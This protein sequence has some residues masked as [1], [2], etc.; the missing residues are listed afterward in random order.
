MRRNWI[1][2]YVD[3]CLR[4]T[5][6][7]ELSNEERWSWIGFLLLAGDSPFEGK[8]SLTE[9]M[10]YTDQQ[11]ASLIK[12]PISTLKKAKEKMIKFEKIKVF[13]NNIIQIVNWKRYQSDYKR[14]K[15]HRNP[16]FLEL[17][18]SIKERDGYICQKCHK[19]ESKLEVPLCIH[20]IDNDPSNNHEDNLITLCMTCHSQLYKKAVHPTRK[21][22]RKTQEDKFKEIVQGKSSNNKFN[23]EREREREGEREKKRRKKENINKYGQ[24]ELDKF[25]EEFWKGYP[26][27]IAKEY[28]KEKFMILARKGLIKDLIQATNGYMD[29]LKHR[30]INDNFEQEPMNPATFL[31]KNRWKDYKDFKY[32]P[33]L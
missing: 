33:R 27:K 26:K 30:R 18:E 24:N 17:R 10:G 23:K 22:E 15:P 9:N 2:L 11:I 29:F 7:D 20:H 6:M 1:K 8:I 19:H 25:F 21:K 5:M 28:A 4:G 16:K 12:T 3:Q 13:D 31:S 32:E 14:Q